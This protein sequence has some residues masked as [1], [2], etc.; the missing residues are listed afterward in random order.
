MEHFEIWA[1][2]L[3]IQK[4]T[5]QTNFD[6]IWRSEPRGSSNIS[7]VLSFL[8][9]Y[10]EEETNNWN[11]DEFLLCFCNGTCSRCV[12]I[13]NCI[14]SVP[15][16]IFKLCCMNEWEVLGVHSKIGF[17]SFYKTVSTKVRHGFD[18]THNTKRAR[19]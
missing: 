9:I 16:S 1:T 7:F 8:L 17:S 4:Q 14:W 18:H 15:V 10:E 2:S 3:K 11:Y 5:N 19:M 6:I 12:L 13:I